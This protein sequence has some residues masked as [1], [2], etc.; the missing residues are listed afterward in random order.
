MPSIVKPLSNVLE[1][2]ERTRIRH[3]NEPN[4]SAK[5]SSYTSFWNIPHIYS[6]CSLETGYDR[7]D[8]V[9]ALNLVSSDCLQ[10]K[11]IHNF[12]SF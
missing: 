7:R 6:Y 3:N 8:A 12:V 10:G 11:I 1:V 2:V 4:I 9:P 5:V